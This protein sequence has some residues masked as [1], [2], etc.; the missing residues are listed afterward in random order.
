[1]RF[2]VRHNVKVTFPVNLGICVLLVI[3]AG[4]ATTDRARVSNWEDPDARAV[5]QLPSA[6]VI[7][8]P[9]ASPPSGLPL[10][11]RPLAKAQSKPSSD[12][13]VPLQRWASNNGLDLLSD[14]GAPPQYT[15]RSG[16]GT[17]ALR[18]G[19]QVMHFGGIDVRLGFPPQ[20]IDGQPYA[21]ETD[22]TK[23]MQPL[24]VA[25]P[26]LFAPGAHV[27]VIDPGHGGQDAGTRSVLGQRSEKEFTLDWARR[28]KPLLEL[29]NAVVLLTRGSDLDLAISNRVA[30]A[31]Q[32]RATLFL[33][34]HFNSAAPNEV[35]AGL[36]TSLPHSCGYALDL[37]ARLGRGFQPGFSQQ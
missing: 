21:H 10:P 14:G 17:L 33:S 23:T 9:P 29:N 15:I 2:D 37:N 16:N 30:F 24:L 5:V 6:P 12:T 19:S 4:C 31:Q 26:G 11:Q 25:D 20:L 28:L 13:W 35:E 36:E 34:L 1:M 3:A 22:V 7:A 8:A 32:H 27:I 18:L